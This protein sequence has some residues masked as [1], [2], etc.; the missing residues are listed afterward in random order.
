M[1]IKSGRAH[2]KK[3]MLNS[4]SRGFT[5]LELLISLTI[6]A[7]IVVIMFGAFRIGIRAWEKGEK[8]VDI[9]QKQRIVLDLIKRQLASTCVTDARNTEQQ[10]I[11]FKGDNKSI[12][13][14]SHIPLTPGGLPG[15]V[16]VKYAVAHKEGDDRDRLAF[17]ERSVAL[18]DKKTGAGEPD[19]ADFSELLSGMKSIVFEYLK[20][21]PDEKESPW[22]ESWD[23]AIE[24]GIPRAIRIT[25]REN[26]K[27]APIYVIA[28]AG[29]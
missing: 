19:E 11:L 24:K 6:V 18:P 26:D 22:Q 2:S 4:H 25:L 27:K 29:A 15:L 5:L 13:F 10:P 1:L 16:Y 14:V 7:M 9:R 20:S 8:D 3:G 28:A 23:P 12:E 21:R 17:Y